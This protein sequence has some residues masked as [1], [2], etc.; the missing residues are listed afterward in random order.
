MS[1]IIPF[2]FNTHPVRVI[3]NDAG[4]PW[5]V[6]K[7]V[8][9]ILGYSDA[10]KMINRLD[11]DE[12]SNR[13]VGGLGSPSGGRGTTLINE[14]GLYTVILGSQ[15]LQAKPFKRWVTHDVLPSIRKT[16]V[17]SADQQI[18]PS[19]LELQIA[20]SAA[21]MLR[22]SDT[23]KI[24][25]LGSIC[26]QKGIGKDFLPDYVDEGLTKALGDLLK[27]HCSSLSARAVNQ[28]LI[29]M[30]YLEELE[31]RA[32]GGKTKKFKSITQIGLKYGK[33]DTSTANQNQ[34]QPRYYVSE[35]PELLALINEWVTSEDMSA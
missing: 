35:F 18:P 14:S 17:Y 27:D 9:E 12:K 30:G 4:D 11:E 28:M 22:M 6:A 15:K 2:D 20:E 10:H 26:K 21:R 33:N 13:Q 8:A 16:G 19:I 5:F 3:N 24:R 23:S 32:T 1:N 29:A 31:R 34:T 7:D 25:M